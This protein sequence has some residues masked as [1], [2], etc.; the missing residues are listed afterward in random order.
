MS[1]PCGEPKP[2][3]R[4]LKERLPTRRC[5]ARSGPPLCEHELVARIGA[6]DEPS[7]KP[8]VGSWSVCRP[9][10]V[11]FECGAPEA[12]QDDPPLGSP[13]EPRPA[14]PAT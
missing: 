3:I 5:S 12:T 9:V 4:T 8:R 6:Q 13:N 11:A 1:L 14:L 10:V 7:G 2:A